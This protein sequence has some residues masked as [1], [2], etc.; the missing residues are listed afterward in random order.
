[1]SVRV[2]EVRV[3]GQKLNDIHDLTKKVDKMTKITK[4][5]AITATFLAVVAAL[6]IGVVGSWLV[7]HIENGMWQQNANTPSSP[8]IQAD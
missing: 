8:S 3:D 4:A 7:T 6:G 5:L 2:T 1:V